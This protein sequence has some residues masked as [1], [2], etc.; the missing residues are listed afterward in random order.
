MSRGVVSVSD[1]QLK[2]AEDMLHGMP[3]AV[4]KVLFRAINRGITTAR[5]EAVKKVRERYHVKAGDVRSTMKLDRANSKNLLGRVS[6]KGSAM[7]LISFD[8]S[9]KRP[10]PARRRPYTARIMRGGGR[11]S[12]GKSFVARM[13][14]G[15]LGVYERFGPYRR[16]AGQKIRQNYGPS[17][18]QMLGSNDV[19]EHVAEKARDMMDRRI[20]H[21][22]ER[23]LGGNK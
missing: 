17:V 19:V 23:V 21:E 20:D 4:Q 5:A 12:L 15:A 6:S 11:Q 9:P 22:I 10:N 3:G 18:P 8:V 13:P 16:G 7:P 14:S 2:K 1:E